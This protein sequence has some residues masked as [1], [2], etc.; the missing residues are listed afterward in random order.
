M[1]TS[2]RLKIY[3]RV[4]FN[5]FDSAWGAIKRGVWMSLRGRSTTVVSANWGSVER[6]LFQAKETWILQ[7]YSLEKLRA[8]VKTSRADPLWVQ[9]GN[10]LMGL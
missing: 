8:G 5:Y 4:D 6:I 9:L 10:C 7:S 2:S 1:L 3:S